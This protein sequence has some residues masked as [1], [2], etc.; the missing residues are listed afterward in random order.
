MNEYLSGFNYKRCAL[1][2][3]VARI[4]E[5]Q[6]FLEK[7]SEIS[8]SEIE[9]LLKLLYPF[10]PFLSSELY[11]KVFGLSPNMLRDTEFDFEKLLNSQKINWKI[12]KKGKFIANLP[13]Q[14]QFENSHND[15]ISY[16]IEKKMITQ[17]E[18][19]NPKIIPNKNII[20]F[21]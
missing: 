6:N 8:K 1:H 12:M 7:K 9:L 11:S 21:L 3:S 5:Y 2:V 13:H 14:P 18:S 17:E 15:L 20:N 4:Y 10:A 16:L 19:K